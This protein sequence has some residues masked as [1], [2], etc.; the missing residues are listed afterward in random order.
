MFATTVHGNL[1]KK[2]KKR[3]KKKEKKRRSL[4]P[5]CVIP[6]IIHV[7]TANCCT[8]MRLFECMLSL[9]VSLSLSLPRYGTHGLPIKT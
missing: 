4:N 1:K 5:A 9:S 6:N 8:Q 2:K 3:K 7:A